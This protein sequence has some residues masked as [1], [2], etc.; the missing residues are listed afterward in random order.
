MLI[1]LTGQGYAR[2]MH[3][4][5]EN[6]AEARVWQETNLHTQDKSYTAAGGECG[7]RKMPANLLSAVLAHI[8]EQSRTKRALN[9]RAVKKCLQLHF[10][11]F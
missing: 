4:A 9:R 10:A 7:E 5:R 8:L 3:A 1:F 11:A 6:G 2:T